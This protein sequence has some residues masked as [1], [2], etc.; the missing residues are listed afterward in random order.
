MVGGALGF[1]L[2]SKIIILT[3][4]LGGS[5]GYS[6]AQFVYQIVQ[7]MID[8]NPTYLYYGTIA[9]CVVAGILVALLVLKSIIIIGTSFLGG[10]IAM[11]GVSV[12]FGNYLDEGQFADL[13]KNDEEK[14]HVCGQILDALLEFPNEVNKG[15]YDM[16]FSAYFNMF[17]KL[18]K[19]YGLSEQELVLH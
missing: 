18:V 13:I 9:V 7:S 4:L 12:I 10:Y 8:W 14:Y 16:A 2:K 17:N 11:R 5:M 1:L 6:I 3:I 15:E 19:H